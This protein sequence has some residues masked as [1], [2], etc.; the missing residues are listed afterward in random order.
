[1]WIK[2]FSELYDHQDQGDPEI[3]VGTSPGKEDDFPILH[4]EVEAAIRSLKNGKAPGIDN[5]PTELIKEGGSITIMLMKICKKIWQGGQWPST[6]TQSLIL[7]V[8]K[9]GTLQH[10]KN[11]QSHQSPP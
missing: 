3:L 10:C 5:V 6:W 1:M 7:T 9:K 8:P 2:Y 11:Y 4:E